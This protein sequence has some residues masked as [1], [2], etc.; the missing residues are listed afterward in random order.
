[1]GKK[2]GKG[3]SKY[4]PG[5]KKKNIMIQ[6]QKVT[7]PAGKRKRVKRGENSLRITY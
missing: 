3:T 5:C 6:T 7:S 4:K 1:M 2:K